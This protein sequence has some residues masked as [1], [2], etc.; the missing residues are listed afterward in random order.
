MFEPVDIVEELKKEQ[1]ALQHVRGLLENEAAR[2]QRIH[3]AVLSSSGNNPL[4]A[5]PEGELI[6]DL[7]TIQK[8]CEDYRLRFL[9]GKYFKGEIPYE[10]LIRIKEI[11]RRTGTELNEFM[12]I[13]PAG[14]FNLKDEYEDPVLL[15]PLADGRFLFIHKWGNDLTWYRKIL[16]F[17]VRNLENYLKTL[18]VLAAMFTMI[19][20]W[21]WIVREEALYEESYFYYRMMLFGSCLTWMFV[22]SFYYMFVSRKNFSRTD[23]DNVYFNK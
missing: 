10:A 18:V 17:P 21:N 15:S 6:F 9:P 19:I 14:L 16:Y 3:A 20:P 1:D 13:A 22:M 23:W 5:A 4:L 7:A 12:I 8:I 11:E 2:D